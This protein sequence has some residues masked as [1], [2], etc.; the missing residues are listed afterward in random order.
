MHDSTPKPPQP[1]AG[2]GSW[3]PLIRFLALN[4]GVGLGIGVALAAL[5]VLGDVGGL[6]GLIAG[7]ENPWL[8][9]FLLYFMLALTYGSV[10]MGIAVMTLPYEDKDKGNG[11]P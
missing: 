7:A 10:A 1:A 4:L 9:M 3:P 11:G 6:K 8:A 2:N 5:I